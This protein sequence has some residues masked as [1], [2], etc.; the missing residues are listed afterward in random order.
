MEAINKKTPWYK[1]ALAAPLAAV[2][3]FTFSCQQDEETMARE[4]VAQSYEE[5][6][7]EIDKVKTQMDA[8]LDKYYPNKQ[9]YI[10]AV[11]AVIAKSGQPNALPWK[12]GL[13]DVASDADM[14]KMKALSAKNKDL[15]EKLMRLPDPDGTYTLVDGMPEPANGMKEFYEY[16][17]KNIR[18]PQEARSEEVEGKVFVQFTVNEYGELANF[19]ALKGIGGGCDEEA[20]RVLEN[21]PEWNPGTTDGKPV[22]VKMVMPITFKLDGISSKANHGD[23]GKP[24]ASDG[25]NLSEVIVVGYR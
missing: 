7:A 25:E 10:N 19:K 14:E 12:L 2:M 11:N 20:I 4:A 9:D 8:I 15:K 22:K 3:F 21:A 23:T 13:Q 18:Y 24:V 16:I 1:L 17:S 5:V 6:R